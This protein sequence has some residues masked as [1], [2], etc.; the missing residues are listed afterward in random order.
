MKNER[1]QI[2]RVIY[3]KSHEE[4]K[5]T[6]NMDLH[7]RRQILA[8]ADKEAGAAHETTAYAE[9][10]EPYQLHHNGLP[11]EKEVG[12]RSKHTKEKEIA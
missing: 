6:E 10:A 7:H 8:A 11:I 1:G 3:T 4:D 5:Q 12:T 9:S 2:L